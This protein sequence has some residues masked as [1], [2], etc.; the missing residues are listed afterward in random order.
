MK[1]TK[2]LLPLILISTTAAATIKGSASFLAK[3]SNEFLEI[4]GSELALDTSKAKVTA[5]V[6]SGIFS[7]K[8]SDMKTGIE[9]RDGHLRKYLE[10]EKFPLIELALDP[11]TVGGGTKKTFSGKLTIHG[12][13]KPVTGIVEFDSNNATA[14]FTIP[15]ITQY[16]VKGVPTY[17]NFTIGKSIDVVAKINIL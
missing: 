16:G 6:I 12:V 1:S 11:V 15:D 13:T 10:A 2:F 7:A 4:E 5:G 9:M 8:V 17:K 14:R 3:A